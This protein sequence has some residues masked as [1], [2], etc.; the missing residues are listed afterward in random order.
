MM[1]SMVSR[2]DQTGRAEETANTLL[3]VPF[4]IF[5]I[6]KKNH[7]HSGYVSFG[8]IGLTGFLEI[9]QSCAGYIS[10]NHSFLSIGELRLA[11]GRKEAA[12]GRNP[13]NRCYNVIRETQKLSPR[14]EKKVG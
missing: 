12:A 2:V 8:N 1:G 5:L 4:I 11:L 3:V 13:N 7:D 14:E 6:E 9:M 10:K